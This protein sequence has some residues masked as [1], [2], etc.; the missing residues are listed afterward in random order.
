MSDEAQNVDESELVLDKSSLIE[1]Q[2]RDCE[3][4]A[5]NESALSDGEAQKQLFDKESKERSFDAG[6]KVLILLPIPGQAP[7]LLRVPN[8][9]HTDIKK[10]VTSNPC[11]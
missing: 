5:L 9:K 7:N 6:E 8:S 11:W 2:R 4:M 3:L 1:A 10:S